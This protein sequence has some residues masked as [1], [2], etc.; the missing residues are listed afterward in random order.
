MQGPTTL[1]EALRMANLHQ[2]QED[3]MQTRRRAAENTA[4]MRRRDNLAVPDM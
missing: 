2:S 4:A 1:S 3:R